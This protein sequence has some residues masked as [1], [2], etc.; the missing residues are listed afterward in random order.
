MNMNALVMDQVIRIAGVED[1]RQ[2]VFLQLFCQAVVSELA[3][4]LRPGLTPEDC[5][6]EFI[7]AASLYVLAALAETD[8]TVNLQH[9]QVGDL[10]IKPGGGENAARCLREQATRLL[11]PYWADNFSFQGV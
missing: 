6:T 4:K 8:E 2:E 3:A 1:P 5:R 9:I 10:S 7:V 11:Q